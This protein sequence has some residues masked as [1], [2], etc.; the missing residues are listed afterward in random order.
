MTIDTL[1][2]DFR[3]AVGQLISKPGFAVTAV[4]TLALGLGATAAIFSVVRGVVMEPLPYPEPDRLVRLTSPVPGVEKDGVWN[5]STAQFFHFREHADTLEDIGVWQITALTVRMGERTRRAITAIVSAD[6]MDMLGARAVHGRMINA[7]DDTPDAAS[8]AMLSHGYWQ[9]EFAGDASVIG[10]TLQIESEA[11]E[12][13]GVMAPG[14]RLPGAAGAPSLIERPEIWTPQRLNPAGP[15]ANAHVYLAIGKLAGNTSIDRAQLEISRMTA[16]LAEVFPGVY[17]DDFT[18]RFGFQTRLTPLKAYQLGDMARH[19]WLLFGAIALVLLIALA[20]VANLFL[21]R[22]EGRH[23]ELAVRAALGADF[24]TI[25]RHILM[26]SMMLAIAGGAL[27]VVA[28]SIGV[29][30]LTAS[31]PDTLPRVDNIGLDAGVVVFVS[32]LAVI[33]GLGLAVLVL[34]R[35]RHGATAHVAGRESGRSTASF[36][37]Q[38]MRAVLVAGQVAFA[39]V[40]LVAAGLLIQSFQKLNDIDPGF[41]SK[42]VIRTQLH[43]PGERYGTHAG[44]WQFYSMLLDRVEALPQVASAG[45]GN[46]LPLSGEY[47]CWGQGFADAAV[48]GRLSEIGGTTCGDIVVTAP[49]YFETLGVPVLAG[50]T[51]TPAD[52]DNPDTGAVVVSQA[53][54]ERFWPDEDPLGKG[55][56]PL[57]APGE[58]PRYYRVV[59]VVGD[60]PAASLEGPRALAVYYPIIPRP[61]EGFP[62]SPSLRLNLLVKTNGSASAEVVSAIRNIVQELDVAVAVGQTETMAEVVEGSMGRVSFSMDLLA[63]SA[64]AALFLA[65]VGLYGVIAYLVARRTNEIG[66]RMALGAAQDRVKRTVM[67]SSMKMVGIGFAVGIVVAVFLTRLMRGMFYDIQPGNPAIYLL[68]AGIMLAVTLCAAYFP[69]RHASR[70]QPLEALRH[71]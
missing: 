10:R 17:G 69:A 66:I 9:R 39:L 52:L 26:E 37:R 68:A 36:R 61:G 33:A 46:P 38:R 31:A 63:I 13:I 12:I 54:A 34:V 58:P 5:L 51:F 18:E 16:R 8:V 71:D 29:R 7:H 42:D 30:L 56:R 47:G 24:L 55:V 19:L 3:Y 70:V 59:G 62:V 44:V 50:R 21:V 28:A 4:L 25:A 35:Y 20:N 65:A 60:L 1:L 22:I 11:F 40:L 53:F 6:M 27:A 64:I 23:H 57:V 2:Q 15:F 48:A 45:A 43:L 67:V 14:V 41:A 32:M 49:G